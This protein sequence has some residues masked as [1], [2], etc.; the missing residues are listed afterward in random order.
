MQVRDG[1]VVVTNGSPIV[2]GIY[3][4]TLTGVTGAAV[5]DEALIFTGSGAVGKTASYADG[6]LSCWITSSAQ[7]AALDVV[8]QSP[9]A[10]GGTV[11]GIAFAP[12]WGTSGIPTGSIFV[13]SRSGVTYDV[14]SVDAP[15]KL[16]L[17]GNYVGATERAVPFSITTSFTPGA[18]IAYVDNGDLDFAVISKR[19]ALRID[20]LVT[21]VLGVGLDGSMN[22]GALQSVRVRADEN[23][24]ELFTALDVAT[25]GTISGPVTISNTLVVSGAITATGGVLT[26]AV[27]VVGLPNQPVFE[28]SWDNHGDSVTLRYGAGFWKQADGTVHLRGAITKTDLPNNETIFILPA[29]YRP[30]RLLTFTTTD[31]VGSIFSV[32][33]ASTGAVSKT[34]GSIVLA[35]LLLDGIAFR[36]EA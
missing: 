32:S 4:L 36:A 10:F 21:A 16:T 26:E 28:N 6:V 15:G 3:R 23:A 25:G 9:T 7:P 18:G 34:G 22:E 33:V 35:L 8:A 19:G 17:S 29:G 12:A 2:Y 27:R 14:A 13:R 5:A 1:T 31:D 11:S 30:S 24:L 20:Q